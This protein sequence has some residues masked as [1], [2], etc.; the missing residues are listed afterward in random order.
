MSKKKLGSARASAQM[1][2]WDMAMDQTHLQSDVLLL[3]REGHDGEK[4]RRKVA[5]RRTKGRSLA[6]GADQSSVFARRMKLFPKK[7]GNPW[8]HLWKSSFSLLIWVISTA[9][10]Q[11]KRAFFGFCLTNMSPLGIFSS[12]PSH[13]GT[14]PPIHLHYQ[15]PFNFLGC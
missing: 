1:S 14:R 10:P 9:M 12:D 13:F 3:L 4:M 2:P 8:I 5:G 15:K 6:A 7:G 11:C